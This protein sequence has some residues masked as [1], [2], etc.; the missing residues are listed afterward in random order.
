MKKLRTKIILIFIFLISISFSGFSKDLFIFSQNRVVNE[1]VDGDIIIF[2][3]EVKIDSN[4]KGDVI[5]FWSNIE[6]KKNGV[7][8]GDLIIIGGTFK[9]DIKG[10]VNGV[11]VR[12]FRRENF[13]NFAGNL[14]KSDLKK[15]SAIFNLGVFVLWFF[16]SL[17]ILKLYKEKIVCFV[18]YMKNNPLKSFGAGLLFVILL[19]SIFMIFLILVI[20]VIGIPLIF[21]YVLFLLVIK[22]IER[23]V[24]FYFLG[25]LIHSWIKFKKSDALIILIGVMVFMLL[26]FSG[27][28]GYLIATVVDIISI[29]A[30]LLHF[31]NKII[32]L[33][34]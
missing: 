3:S 34:K 30:I 13:K 27:S 16:I 32:S 17:G 12:F 21:L 14:F 19:F 11:V 20:F 18:E 5:S 23:V 15:H 9:K 26:R 33:K 4:V 8:G 10:K 22:I 2:F 24:I 7:I 29:G 25:E 1:E 31:K 28:I 6:V